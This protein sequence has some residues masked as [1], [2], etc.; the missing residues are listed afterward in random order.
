[1][2]SGTWHVVLQFTLIRL[3]LL[4]L[5]LRLLSVD[6][7]IINDVVTSTRWQSLKSQCL[8]TLS[9]SQTC[10]ARFRLEIGLLLFRCL[11][12]LSNSF[13][14][15]CSTSTSSPFIFYLFECLLCLLQVMMKSGI[16]KSSLSCA[17]KMLQII[18][19]AW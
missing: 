14:F 18:Y 8:I 19:S 10:V 3:I 6:N 4:T 17:F 9:F 11:C 5:L 2:I 13:N 7:I 15:A 16:R 1:M 12:G